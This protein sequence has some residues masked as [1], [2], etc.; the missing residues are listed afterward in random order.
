MLRVLGWGKRHGGLA[1]LYARIPF[2][3][4][5]A[6]RRR[7]HAAAGMPMP[8]LPFPTAER[9]TTRAK[10]V[11]VPPVSPGVNLLGY[12]RGEFGVAENVRSYARAVERTGYP[13]LIFNFDVGAA[14]RQHD[15]S[16]EKHFSDTLR[17]AHNIFFIN[18]DQMQIARDVLGREAFAGHRNVGFWVW[19]LERF[20]RDWYGAFDLVDEVWVPTEFVRTAIGADTRKPVL[21]MPK[22][23]E[24][25][26]PS[27]MDRAHFGLP[28]DEFVF[29]FSYDFNSFAARK[30][31][32]AVIAAFRHA[33]VGDVRGVRLLVKSTN[34]GRF[35]DQLEALRQIVGDDPRIEIRDGFLSRE[36]M[37]GLQNT[38]DCYVSLHRSEGFGLGMAECMYLGKPVIATGY[39]GNLDFM[40]RDNSLLVDYKMIPLRDGDYPYWQ[41]QHWADPDVDHAARLMRQVFEE[42]GFARG[43]GIAAAASIRRSN[44]KAVCGAAVTARL[45]EIEAGKAVM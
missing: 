23:I 1:R 22:A 32:E 36:E 28:Q 10:H 9:R 37:F 35:P 29:L 7:V 15:A 16:M 11:Q 38:I 21:R 27:G 26:A 8:P 13:F 33:F 18:A 20:P 30:N 2:A 45:Q 39:S 6:L 31:P 3:W 43:I 40:D 19:E 12:A 5:L 41:G 4:R 34:G 17:Y 14:S 25:D 24:F 44:S 42:P